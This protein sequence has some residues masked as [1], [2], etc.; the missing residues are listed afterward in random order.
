[1]LEGRYFRTETSVHTY[2]TLPDEKIHNQTD[3]KFIDRRWNSGILDVRFVRGANCDADHCLMVAK[4]RERLAA[5][6]QTAQKSE[7]QRFNL[8]TLSE[9]E[10]RKWYDIKISNKFAAL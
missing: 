1:M 6:K 9:L 10:V 7:V 2:G 5:S 8:K 3:C 4:V